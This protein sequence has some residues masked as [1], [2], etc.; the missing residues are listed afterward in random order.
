MMITGIGSLPFTDID[1]AIDL[2]F[3]T[4]PEIPFWPQLP[5]R[6][7]REN[8]YST[9]LDGV[10]CIK[11]DDA[12]GA[13]CM[14]TKETKGIEEFYEH[15]AAENL[16]AFALSQES[17]PGFYRFLDR[18]GEV[19][20]GAKFIKGQ[21]TGPFSMGLGLPDEDGKPVIYNFG[22]FDII[23]KA[24]HMKARWMIEKIKQVAPGKEL[25]IFF[26][27]PYMVSFGSA[28]VSIAKEEATSL[29]D[30]VTGGLGAKRGV[31]CCGNTDWSVLF[32]SS[33]D[34]VNYDAFSYLETIFYF[35]E[36][37]VK[38]L[39]RGSWICP[40]IIPS[41]EK[42][43]ETSLTDI[44]A[45]WATFLTEMDKIGID[46]K[47]KEWLFTTSCGL[48]SLGEKETEAA[49]KLLKELSTGL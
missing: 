9:F 25:I 39:G 1:G 30:E 43:L 49:M 5:K 11:T 17:A 23:K 7:V 45:L 37:L 31:H 6:S 47:R 44:K 28:Y 10:P 16:D 46:A 2:I 33:I 19:K 22:Y 42:V 21:L 38:Y 3:S 41:S 34:I 18:L 36:D 20:D 14:D 13:V 48:G 29:F 27:E 8:M 32:N 12:K 15:F 24:L 4:C 26:D 35:K 40:G